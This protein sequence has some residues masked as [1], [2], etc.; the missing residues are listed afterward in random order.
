M[1][2]NYASGGITMAWNGQD[3][4]EG[5][6]GI[7]LDP[8]NNLQEASYDLKGKRTLSQIAD[9]SATL[10]VTYT[11]TDNTVKQLETAASA[12]QLTREFIQVPIEG[13]GV[14]IFEDP[15]G[16]TGSF[17]AWNVALT[18]TGSESW[19]ASVGERTVTFDV[20]KLIRHEDPASVLANIA[21]YL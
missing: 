11:Q 9:Q 6:K 17:V 7:D 4:S 10:S 2:G 13:E 20:E 15:T 5:Y 16:N 8:K 19:A 21:Q 14:I 18:S 12:L 3:I 1:S